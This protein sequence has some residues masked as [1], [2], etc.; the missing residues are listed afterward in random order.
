MALIEP[1]MHVDIH[2]VLGMVGTS[3]CHLVGSWLNVSVLWE[4]HPGRPLSHLADD[5]KLPK[6]CVFVTTR[7]KYQLHDTR[8]SGHVVNH[9]LRSQAI[10]EQ[11]ERLAN[12]IELDLGDG[13]CQTSA[14]SHA[15]VARY[16]RHSTHPAEGHPDKE[17]EGRGS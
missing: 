11:V 10:V 8:W 7:H 1:P 4:A 12:S 9:I 2:S 14:T 15:L 16:C 3:L 17:V 5:R 13:F 6:Q